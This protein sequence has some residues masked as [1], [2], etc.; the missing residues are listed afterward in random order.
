MTSELILNHLLVLE[1]KMVQYFPSI[2]VAEYDW[3][4]NPYAVSPKRTNNLP[5]E[6]EEQLAELQSDHT[7]QLKYGELSLLKFWMLAK[8]EYPEIA[9]EAVNT[10]LNFSTT[11][12]C[13]LGFS[14]L[15]NIKN[16]KRERF[17]SLEQEM[18]VCLSSI[19]PRIELL[20]KK[21]QAQAS[22]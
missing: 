18:H 19:R 13:E 3:V 16:K 12:L 17:L 6:K 20:C 5:L 1:D 8:E 2:T 21:R 4:R 7:L 15:T 10:L 9:V 11:Y 22:H 14:A